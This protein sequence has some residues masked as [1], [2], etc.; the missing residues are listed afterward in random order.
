MSNFIYWAF[1]QAP[2][3]VKVLASFIALFAMMTLAALLIWLSTT[4]YDWVMIPAVG[5]AMVAATVYVY[6]Q[7]AKSRKGGDK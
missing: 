2:D 4:D 1:N 7:Y 5:I 6:D 3:L